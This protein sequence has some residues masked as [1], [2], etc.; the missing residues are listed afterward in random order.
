MRNGTTKHL[1]ITN[2]T[3]PASSDQEYRPTTSRM[4]SAETNGVDAVRPAQARKM[5]SPL[6]PSF[7]VSAP[8]KVIVFGEHAVVHGKVS[9]SSAYDLCPI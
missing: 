2:G 4:N 5:S 1:P 7:M 3:S 9:R 8:G 6:A